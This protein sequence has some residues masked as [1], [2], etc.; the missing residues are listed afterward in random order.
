MSSPRGFLPVSDE[1]P[2]RGR[3]RTGKAS[4]AEAKESFFLRHINRDHQ[5]VRTMP[6]ITFRRTGEDE[7]RIYED[8]RIVGELFRDEDYNRPGGILYTI[9]LAED[10]RGP[11]KGSRAFRHPGDG[12]PSSRHASVPVMSAAPIHFHCQ[13]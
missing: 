12:D 5:V 4:G 1:A 7:A 2:R 8:G 6:Q 13:R 11:R 9:H 10:F 3:E